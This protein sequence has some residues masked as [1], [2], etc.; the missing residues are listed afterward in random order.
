MTK[1]KL[2]LGAFVF[3]AGQ[4]VAAWRHESS[5]AEHL[6]DT[7]LY[8]Q[9]AVIAESGKL[10]MLLILEMLAVPE[11]SPG[12]FDDA[13]TYPTPDTMTLATILA[14]VTSKIGIGVTHTT[15][16]ND[17]YRVAHKFSTLSHL[18]K[19]RIGWNMVTTQDN[20]VAF[21]FSRDGHFEHTDRYNRAGEFV[22]AVDE[23]WQN[24]DESKQL[25]FKGNYFNIQGQLP[26][27]P[28]TYGRPI[29]VQAGS[30]A[31]GMNFGAQYADAI[32]TAQTNIED[33]KK[34][35]RDVKTLATTYGRSYDEIKIMPGLSPYI[36]D[37][38]EEAKQLER[39]LNELTS[40]EAGLTYLKILVD[41]DLSQ[42]DLDAPAPVHLMDPEK[43][44][45]KKARVEIVRNKAIAENFT[46]RQLAQWTSLGGGHYPFIGTPQQL[47]DFMEHWLEEEACDGFV[48]MPPIYPGSLSDFVDKV[49]PILQDKGIFRTEYSGVTL[50]H[51]LQEV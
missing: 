51:H 37:T 5:A 6:L 10:D 29:R 40:I 15:S 1:K 11:K 45:D 44:N 41:V 33:A 23:L 14:N 19:G 35:Y 26:V 13:K 39:E 20:K 30:S 4:H 24:I 46:L 16:Y 21:N 28:L 48:I 50:Q 17:P 49:V 34:F 47:A 27:P 12:V 2:H 18:T 32:F 38:E 42:F 9:L 25:Q 7:H 31:S 8:E 36:A 3:S 22:K 43:N